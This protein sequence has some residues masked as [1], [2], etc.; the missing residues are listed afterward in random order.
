MAYKTWLFRSTVTLGFALFADIATGAQDGH[1][2]N[3][4]R[5]ECL[6]YWARSPRHQRAE[7]TMKA[8]ASQP[9]AYIG[10]AP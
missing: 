1:P 3:P 4:H 8:A 5:Q 6:C 7:N 9:L 2:T 10:C